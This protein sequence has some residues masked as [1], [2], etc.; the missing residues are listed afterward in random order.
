MTTRNSEMLPKPY[1]RDMP[2][3][4]F[5]DQTR[6]WIA[7]LPLA[8]IEQHGPH[9]PVGV[10]AFIGEGL[11]KRCVDALPE[12]LPV[13]FLPVQEICKSNEHIS[14]PGTLTLDW[15]VVIRGWINIGESVARAGVRTL[16]LITSHGGNVAPMGVAAR[17][18][19]EK[20]GLRVI[21]TSWG[22]LGKWHEI[23]QYDGPLI[24]IHAGES[25]TSEMLVLRPDLVD[26]DAARDFQSDQSRLNQS[27]RKLGYHGASADLSWLVEDLNPDG[28]VGDPTRADASLGERDL[29]ETVAG[30]IELMRDI[31]AQIQHEG[32]TP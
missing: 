23:Y 7:V 16:V 24:D 25:E 4:A 14:F 11:V 12:D 3:S 10:D 30:F 17:E 5:D 18:L 20:L 27:A 13:T 21:T 8:A 6:N 9:L 29:A 26:L 32:T 31:A 15:D 22:R 1:W 19:R 2:S 28:A